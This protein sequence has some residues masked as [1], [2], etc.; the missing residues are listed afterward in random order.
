MMQ[1]IA[2]MEHPIFL[3]LIPVGGFMLFAFIAVCISS[4]PSAPPPPSERTAD[5]YNAAAVLMAAKR[6]YLDMQT[7]LRKSEIEA[8]RIE[9]LH[10]ERD[11]II[12][13]DRKVRGLSAELDAKRSA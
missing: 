4:T 11:Q 13:H 7:E 8:A 10:K 3:L 6:N 5:E 12:A 9:A 2:T 1:G